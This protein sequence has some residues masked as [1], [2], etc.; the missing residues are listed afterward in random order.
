MQMTLTLNAS[1]KKGPAL[2]KLS[3]WA[4]VGFLAMA[5]VGC[6]RNPQVAKQKYLDKGKAY[7]QKGKYNEAEIEF[8]NAIQIDSQ[9]EPAHYELALCYL[10]QGAL[11]R[12]YVELTRA[13]QIAPGDLK[14][15]LELADLLL[16]GRKASDARDHAEIVLKSD[17]QNARSA[18]HYFRSRRLARGYRQS[19]R[20]SSEGY[21]N[22]CQPI[23]VLCDS[24][25]APSTE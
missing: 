24:G 2:A 14:A 5:L 20:R 17:P 1:A 16:A 25:A 8:E 12:A 9:F 18:S 19:D 13:V 15:Q 3:V 4:L 6:S 22:G 10:K 23:G 11:Q 21:S 7:A